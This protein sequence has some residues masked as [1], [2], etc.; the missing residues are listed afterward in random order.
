MAETLTVA[1]S[2]ATRLSKLPP[3]L[4][5]AIDR[6]KQAAVAEGRDI[7][8]FGIGDPDLPTPDFVVERMAKAIRNGANHH[9]T[10]SIGAAMYREAVAAYMQ[11][12]FG[13]AVDPKTEVVGLLGSKEGIGHLPTALVD[14]GDI[15]LV[16]SPGYPVYTAGTVFAGGLIHTLPLHAEDGWLPRLDEIPPEV[17]KKAKLLYLNYPNNPTAACATMDFF[18]RAVAFAKKYDILLAHDA[19]YV[20]IYFE[21]PPPSILQVAGAR[22]VCIEF[23]SLSKTFNL[24]G[25]RVGF[26]VGHAEALAALAAVKS[27]LDSGIFQATQE[28]AIEALS[29]YDGPEVSELVQTYRQRRDVL[30]EG[31]RAAGWDVDPPSATLL[32]WLPCPKGHDSMDVAKRMLDDAD[33]VVVPGSGFGPTASGFVRFALTVDVGRIREAMGRISK[34]DW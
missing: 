28:A 24:T 2:K 15:V 29:R 11:Q 18:E 16:P 20:D 8:E 10:P 4:F 33:I 26:A 19:A 17:A 6:M 27:N 30:I 14:P 7:I 22:D 31:L 32:A 3:Y 21:Q 1:G 9:Y 34:L 5:V 23:H 25:W 12:R 13:V